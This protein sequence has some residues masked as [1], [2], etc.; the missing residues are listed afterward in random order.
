MDVFIH[1][2]YVNK[3]N[4]VRREQRRRQQLQMLQVSGNPDASRGSPGSPA[5]CVTPSGVS[6]FSIM[7]PTAASVSPVSGEPAE[8]RIFDCIKPY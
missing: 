8:H 1:E 6:P 7:S 4:E 3:R 2:D 5:A